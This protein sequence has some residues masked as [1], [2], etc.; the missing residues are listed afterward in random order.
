MVC[1][2]T[3]WCTGGGWQLLCS[4]LRLGSSR[5]GLS[6]QETAVNSPKPCGKGHTKLSLD[7]RIK[8]GSE[9][10]VPVAPPSSP[11]SS[12][13]GGKLMCAK[14]CLAV[15]TSDPDQLWLIKSLSS[16][17]HYNLCKIPLITA[18]LQQTTPHYAPS[19]RQVG[20]FLF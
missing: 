10:I 7:V 17:A 16:V 20:L 2:D 9:K 4:G 3:A 13:G 5:G 14:P 18:T 19:R 12:G 11:P 15:R 8:R 1:Y 6:P